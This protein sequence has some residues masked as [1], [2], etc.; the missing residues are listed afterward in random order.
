MR[1]N[2]P[3]LAIVKFLI[4]PYIYTKFYTIMSIIKKILT[5]TINCTGQISTHRQIEKF[6]FKELILTKQLGVPSYFGKA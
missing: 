4:C 1:S 3:D 2:N 6:P 5:L